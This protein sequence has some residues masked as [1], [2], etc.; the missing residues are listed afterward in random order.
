M[1]QKKMSHMSR[2]AFHFCSGFVQTRVSFL[3]G[4]LVLGDGKVAAELQQLISCRLVKF[5]NEILHLL[6][7]SLMQTDIVSTCAQFK[8]HNA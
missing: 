7:R 1:M 2:T 8:R 3:A 5:Y 4:E 6:Y